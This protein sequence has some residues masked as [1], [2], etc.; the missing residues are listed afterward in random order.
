MQGPGRQEWTSQAGRVAWK[1][2]LSEWSPLIGVPLPVKSDCCVCLSPLPGV[3]R[4]DYP[5]VQAKW[6]SAPRGA[7]GLEHQ[8]E[9]H[10]AAPGPRDPTPP[11]LCKCVSSNPSCNSGHRKPQLSISVGQVAVL[12]FHSDIIHQG[13][14]CCHGP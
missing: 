9:C 7:P 10:P 3:V 5:D 14:G 8:R 6:H 12:L 2:A 4:A 1:L 11:G 13:P